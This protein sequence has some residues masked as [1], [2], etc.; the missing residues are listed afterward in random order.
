MNLVTVIETLKTFKPISIFLYGSQATNTQ[1][2]NSDYEIGVVFKDDEYVARSEIK[3]KIPNKKFSIFPFKLGN[4]QNHSIDTPFQ[5]E[6]YILSLISG[7]AYTI[8]GEK[9]IE[10]LTKPKTTNHHLLM[11]SSFDL[12]TALSAVMAFKNK[13][14]KLANE[15]MYKSL[16][17]ATRNLIYFKTKK[18]IVGYN[19]IYKEA[20]VLNLPE[21]YNQLLTAGYELRNGIR[22]KIDKNLYFQNISY[23]NKFI[24]PTIEKSTKNN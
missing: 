3:E 18:L 11:D 17:Y 9:I 20:K 23:I 8:F 15:L 22:K 19:N 6:I 10:N 24:I 7:N 13:N 14:V 5:K 12:G 16:F 2:K 4:L 1:N 21:E